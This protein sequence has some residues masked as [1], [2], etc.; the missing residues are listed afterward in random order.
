VGG[1]GLGRSSVGNRDGEMGTP[2]GR[3]GRREGGREGTIPSLAI[4][5]ERDGGRE[6]QAMYVP[7]F[8]AA[9]LLFFTTFLVAFFA[10]AFLG[11]ATFLAA[12]DSL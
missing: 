6:G 3:E 10:T 9:G 12:S 11:L 4:W 8:L 2:R 5:R 1:W 7:V